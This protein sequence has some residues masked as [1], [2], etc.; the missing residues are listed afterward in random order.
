MYNIVNFDY[1]TTYLLFL[2]SPG[3]VVVTSDIFATVNSTVELT[4]S[5]EGGPNNMFVWRRQG[6]VISN[7]PVLSIPMV[8]GS[9]GGIYQCTVSNAAGNDFATTSVT[10]MTLHRE[11]IP[12]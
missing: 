1:Y 11:Q 5:A 10:G 2:V 4:C 9:D 12:L 8:T 6:V 3:A 7:N